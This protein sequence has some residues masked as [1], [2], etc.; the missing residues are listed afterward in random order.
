M[1]FPGAFYHINSRENERR[2]N[3]K[4]RKEV[5]LTRGKDQQLGREVKIY[6]CQ[7]YS[8]KALKEMGRH[9]DIGESGVSQAPGRET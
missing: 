5:D 4:S 7:N 8:G 1:A 2:A 6:L 3:F 9:F